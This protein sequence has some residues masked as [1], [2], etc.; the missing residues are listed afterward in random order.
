MKYDVVLVEKELDKGIKEGDIL[1]MLSL[2]KEQEFI[3]IE[4]ESNYSCAMGFI[5]LHAAESINYDLA[6]IKEFLSGVLND[7][8]QETENNNYNFENLNIYM[9][10]NLPKNKWEYAKYSDTCKNE[11]LAIAEAICSL[12]SW[13]NSLMENFMNAIDTDEWKKLLHFYIS[14]SDEGRAIVDATL[15]YL[16]GWNMFSLL[17]KEFHFFSAKNTKT[18]CRIAIKTQDVLSAKELLSEYNEAE[19]LSEWDIIPMENPLA[20]STCNDVIG[21]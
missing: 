12:P 14:L 3:Q 2:L 18:N 19:D 21:E 5:G 7:M 8:D 1:S 17:Q 4:V 6:K 9:S 11:I 20:L 15:M 16:C 13:N 10:R